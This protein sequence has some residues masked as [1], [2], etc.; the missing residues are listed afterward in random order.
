MTTAQAAQ[1]Y[2]A[3]HLVE[4]AGKG[5][6]VYNPH[7]KPVE[8]LPFIYG[9]N[10]G[11]RSEWLS[12]VSI[13][14]DGHQ[15]GG[16]ICSHECYIPHDLGIVEGARK[17][18]HEESYQKHY[19]NGYRMDFVQYSDVKSHAGLQEAFRLSKLLPPSEPEVVAAITVVDDKG[20]ESVIEVKHDT[21]PA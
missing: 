20:T 19:P 14:A 10:N 5:Y 1:H 9:F 6:A 3:L 12:A 15:L 4:W 7:N 2:A 13:S 18:R 11:G 8:E 17:D 16:H 21:N